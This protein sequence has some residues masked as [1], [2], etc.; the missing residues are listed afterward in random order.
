[1][2]RGQTPC[3]LCLQELGRAGSSSV[4]CQP[5]SG[6]AQGRGAGPPCHHSSCQMWGGTSAL[7]HNKCSLWRRTEVPEPGKPTAPADKAEVQSHPCEASMDGRAIRAGCGLLRAWEGGFRFRSV[8][9]G[10][11]QEPHQELCGGCWAHHV[12]ATDRSPCRG[13][14]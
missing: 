2:W 9:L 1:M 10:C 14:I 4:R 12:S 5:R 8:L 11:H 3:W 7:P 13:Y 6:R